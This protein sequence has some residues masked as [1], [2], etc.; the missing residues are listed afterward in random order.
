M[1]SKEKFDEIYQKLVEENEIEMERLREEAR[2]ERRHNR[3]VYSITIAIMAIIIIAFCAMDIKDG[4]L[5]FE[6]VIEMEELLIIPFIFIIIKFAHEKSKRTE[7][8]SEFKMNIIKRIIEQFDDNLEYLPDGDIFSESYREAD[9]ET[10]DIYESDDFIRGKLKNNCEFKM[11]EVLTQKRGRTTENGKTKNNITIFHG[12]FVKVKTPKPFNTVLYLRRDRKDNVVLNL[13]SKKLPFDKLRIQL[14]SSEFEK[15]FDVY[16]SDPIV[17]MQL[18]TADVMQELMKF[19]EEMKMDY[20]ITIKES[21]IYIRFF[22]GPMFETPTLKKSSLD[23]ETIYK[24][25]KMLDFSFD[26]TEKMLKILN[27]TQYD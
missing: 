20:E 8:I 17:G 4:T 12:L 22:S 2:A 21:A 24:Y 25:Y 15:V 11:S 13:T 7:Y 18:L 9:F 23:K 3:I 19:H 16:A 14:D 26:L 5:D 1:V 6:F 10:F 27:E